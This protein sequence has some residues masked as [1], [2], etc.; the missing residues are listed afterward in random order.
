MPNK[1]ISMNKIRQVLRCY[2]PG[3]G[4]KSISSML[5]V[6][7]NTVK[8]YLHIYQKS[9]LGLEEILSLDDSSLCSLFQERE[10][11]PE[12]MSSR[13]KTLHAL[14]PDYSKRL[15]KKGVTRSQLFKEYQDTHPDGYARSRFCTYFQAYLALSCPIA[16]LDTKP[17]TSCTS[18]MPAT[19]CP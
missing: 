9:G 8:K 3:S 15:K 5:N 7:R 4:T 6:S 2:A 14:F 17:V 13:Y 1:A 18:T 10:K 12:E 16:H 11:Q 19:S